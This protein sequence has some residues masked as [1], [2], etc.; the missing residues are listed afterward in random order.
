MLFFILFWTSKQ[1]TDN[2][3]KLLLSAQESFCWKKDREEF[4]SNTDPIHSWKADEKSRV[5]NSSASVVCFVQ[6]NIICSLMGEKI[7]SDV[8]FYSLV[9]YILFFVHRYEMLRTLVPDDFK[10]FVTNVH[11][12]LEKRRMS[13]KSANQVVG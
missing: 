3:C 2:C 11:R 10:K 8:C 1:E 9:K 4:S 6:G 12:I 5:C 13:R 7:Y